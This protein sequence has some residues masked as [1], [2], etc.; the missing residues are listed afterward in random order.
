MSGQYD[1]IIVGAGAAGLTAAIYTA[2]RGLSTLILSQDIGGQAATT[3]AIENYPGIDVAD[4]FALMMTFRAQAEKYGAT[5][6]LEEVTALATV[7]AGFTVTTAK[8]NYR[9]RTLILAQGL[10]HRHL[11]VPG[12]ERYIGKG[13]SY[14]ATCDAPL[15]KGKEVVVVG[16]GNSAMDAALLLAKFCPR[17]TIVTVN[18]EFRGER[19]LID[20]M[21]A[22][23]TITQ[24]VQGKSVSIEGHD[25][26]TGITIAVAGQQRTVAAQGVFVEVG[27]TVNPKLMAHVAPL[28]ER[29]QVVINPQTNGT[30]VPGLFAAGDVTNIIHKQIVISAGE[31]AKAALGVDQYLQSLG[32]RPVSGNTDWA[33]GTPRHHEKPDQHPTLHKL[34]D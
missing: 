32:A 34:N 28:D 16:G 7:D 17:V 33:L 27:Y 13:V 3:S 31:G 18:G 14:C 12:E 1:V 8:Q 11:N 6:V 22:A 23:P 24:I 26:L 21:N 25:A 4:G 20:R 19:V 9:S 10:T 5:V 2:R 15:F 29:N 30:S